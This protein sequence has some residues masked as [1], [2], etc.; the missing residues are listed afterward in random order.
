M[1]AIIHTATTKLIR[2]KSAEI[3]RTRFYFLFFL[4]C[5]VN[6]SSH[7]TIFRTKLPFSVTVSKGGRDYHGEVFSRQTLLN[8]LTQMPTSQS[9]SFVTI[10]LHYGRYDSKHMRY[11]CRPLAGATGFM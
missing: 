4:K 8:F 3:E 7:F 5:H 2:P 6:S 10:A 9:H 11:L 1:V